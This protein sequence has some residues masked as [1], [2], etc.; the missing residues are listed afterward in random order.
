MSQTAL[1]RIKE[2]EAKAAETI[3]EVESRAS[4]EIRALRQGA[5][6]E[7]VKRISEAKQVLADLEVQYKALTGRDFS[8][9]KIATS[10]AKPAKTGEYNQFA[11]AEE[12]AAVLKSAG[13]TLNRKGFNTAGYSLKSAVTF[14]KA[15]PGLFSFE[16]KGPQGSVTLK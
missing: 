2:L 11:S 15:N 1:D 4:E 5:V 7:L 14:A 6:S 13:G 16:Q 8:G 3:K 9:N 12:L 10:E